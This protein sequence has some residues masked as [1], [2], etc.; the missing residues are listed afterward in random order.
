MS[1]CCK[2]FLKFI[3]CREAVPKITSSVEPFRAWSVISTW[4]YLMPTFTNRFVSLADLFFPHRF[5]FCSKPNQTI[6]RFS[7]LKCACVQYPLAFVSS[8]SQ[9]MCCH[10]WIYRLLSRMDLSE[11]S[12]PAE[13]VTKGARVLVRRSAARSS[14]DVGRPPIRPCDISLLNHMYV[15]TGCR[16]VFGSRRAQHREGDEGNQLQT[17]AQDASLWDGSANVGGW[18]LVK[19]LKQP[20]Y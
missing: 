2:S 12:A 18:Y 7:K 3:F 5:A 10:P 17:S 15:C 19:I 16:W 11:L 20:K 9:W 1:G 14:R 13:L 6:E 4:L 8:F